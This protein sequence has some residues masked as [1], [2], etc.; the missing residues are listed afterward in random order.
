MDQM[1][2][3]PGRSAAS[4]FFYQPLVYVSRQFF[5]GIARFDF[6]AGTPIEFKLTLGS[7]NREALD[8]Q[9]R[10]PSNS[11]LVVQRDTTVFIRVPAWEKTPLYLGKVT[12]DVR[13]HKNFHSTKLGHDRDLIIWLPPDY[14][15]TKS[16]RYP[17]LYAHDGQNLFDPRTAFAGVDWAVD[18]TAD[19]LIRAGKMQPVIIVGVANTADRVS[20]YTSARGRDY[21]AFLIDEVKPFIDKNYRTR[22]DRDHTAVMGSSLGGLISFYL[23]WERPEVFGMAACLSGS[24]NWDNAA[25]FQLVE[26]AAASIPNIKLYLDHGSEGD[27]GRLAWMHRTLRDIL[28]GRGF[29]LGKNLAYNFGVGDD[30]HESAW[31]RRVWRPLLFFFGK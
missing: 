6:S 18:E 9:G 29:V 7:W 1:G 8:A 23:A 26:S 27:E 16:Q 11:C 10:V 14:E 22:P 15:K 13:Y 19:S 30:H 24:W 12:A 28:L 2:R 31:A 17:V 21:A 3:V 5:P 20:E 25:A 4:K